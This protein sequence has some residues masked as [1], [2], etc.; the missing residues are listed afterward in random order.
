M[1]QAW[2]RGKCETAQQS[3]R[4]AAFSRTEQLAPID[5]Y[6]AL[7]DLAPTIKNLSIRPSETG[8]NVIAYAKIYLYSRALL[9]A[10]P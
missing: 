6:E 1:E 2:G 3:S 10:S 7:S 8:S 4:S 9:P 5:R